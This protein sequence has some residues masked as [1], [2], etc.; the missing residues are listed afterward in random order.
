M[1]ACDNG[2]R[3]LPY[4]QEEITEQAEKKKFNDQ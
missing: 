1:F 4:S 3:E 2:E